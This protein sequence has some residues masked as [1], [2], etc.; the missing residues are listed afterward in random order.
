MGASYKIRAELSWDNDADLDL[1]AEHDGE[2]AWFGHLPTAT[3]TLNQD[4]HPEC[5][6][7]PPVP[8]IITSNAD[9]IADGTFRFWF[10]RYSTCS[11]EPSTITKLIE[12]ENTGDVKIYVNNERIEPTGKK[13]FNV[14]YRVPN[15]GA[16]DGF[17]KGTLIKVSLK[18]AP[19]PRD[20]V[21]APDADG[22]AKP[23]DKNN[24]NPDPLGGRPRWR[25]GPGGGIF[26]WPFWGW[27]GNGGWDMPIFWCGCGTGGPSGWGG[28][29]GGGGGETGGGGPGG[30]GNGN[31]DNGGGGE[32]VEA[33]PKGPRKI[34]LRYPY[35]MKEIWDAIK[36]IR[37]L[38]GGKCDKQ[39]AP[40]NKPTNDA[41]GTGA[42]GFGGGTGDSFGG[43]GTSYGGSGGF[44]FCTVGYSSFPIRYSNGEIQYSVNDIEIGGNG[45]G[46][47]HTR[48][49]SNQLTETSDVGNGNNWLVRQWTYLV[50][51]DDLVYFISDTQNMVVFEYDSMGDVYNALY[52]SKYKLFHDGD[53]FYIHTPTGEMW[54]FW[55]FTQVDN[56]QGG[57]KRML[58]AAKHEIKVLSYVGGQIEEIVRE[59]VVS[60]DDY[61]ESYFYEYISSG[62]LAGRIST[63]TFRYVNITAPAVTDVRQCGYSYYDG[64]T[65]NGS[66]GDLQLVINRIPDGSG[67]W[68]DNSKEYYRYYKNGDTDGDTGLLKF[69]LSPASFAKMSLTQDPLTATD[70][71]LAEYA[72]H[73]FRYDSN[74]RVIEEQIQGG[75]QSYTFA[76][77]LNTPGTTP[78]HWV[79]KTTETRPDGSVNIVFTNHLG[80]VLLSDYRADNSG[81]ADRWINYYVYDSTEKLISWVKPGTVLSYD[82]YSG[83]GDDELAVTTEEDEGLVHVRVYYPD[84]AEPETCGAA[85][86]ML[87]YLAIKKGTGGDEIRLR[88]YGYTER[89]IADLVAYPICRISDFP[90]ETDQV[91]NRLDTL[92]EYQWL[93]D[94]V[95]VSTFQVKQRITTLPVVT[96][97]QNGDDVAYERT[98]IF[99]SYGRPIWERGPLGMI[100]HLQYSEITGTANKYIQDVDGTIVTLPTGWTTPAGAGLNL[101]TDVASDN[102]GRVTQF[103]EPPHNIDGTMVRRATWIVDR[104]D[105]YENWLGSGYSTGSSPNY[106]STF[107]LL[108][109]VVIN[110]YDTIDSNSERIVANRTSGSGKLAPTNTFDQSDWKRRSAAHYNS[111]GQLVYTRE[112]HLIPSSGNGSIG[113]NYD[114]AEYGYDTAGRRNKWVTAAGTISTVAYNSRGLMNEIW[115]G[116]DDTPTGTNNMVQLE[117]REYDT[118][119]QGLDSLLTSITRHVDA[120]NTR[121][122]E[123]AYDWRDRPILEISELGFIVKKELDNLGRVTRIESYLDE[124]DPAQLRARVD[125]FYDNRGNVY[126]V[127]QYAVNQSDGSIIGKITDL[128]WYDGSDR[129]L[130]YQPG[131][132]EPFQKY[133][134][135]SIGR[136]ATSY[137]GLIGSGTDDPATVTGDYIFEQ[138]TAIYD[139]ASNL[140][141]MTGISRY[142]GNTS[143][144]G[145]LIAPPTSGS[146]ARPSYVAVWYDPLGRPTTGADYGTNNNAS[147]TRPTSAPAASDTV[148]VTT[149]EYDSLSQLI[150]IT[151]AQGRVTKLFYD[152]LGRPVEQIANYVASGTAPDENVT[153]RAEYDAGRLSKV[154]AVNATTGD[155]ET[156]MIYGTTLTESDLA[157][158]DLQSATLFPGGVAQVLL[159][160]NRLS[161]VK[162]FND[163]NGTIHQFTFDELGRQ[164]GDEITTFAS[165]VDATVRKISSAF[166]ANGD[167]DSITSYGVS[168]TIL[169]QVKYEY[170]SIGLLTKEY[171]EHAGVKNGSTPYTGYEYDTT[172][173]STEYTHGLRPTAMVYPNGERVRYDYGTSSGF[174]DRLSRIAQLKDTS[175]SL[176]TQYTDLGLGSLVAEDFTEPQVKLNYGSTT[177][178]SYPGFD[179]LNRIQ[180][181]LWRS[182]AGGGV[183]REKL[184]YGFDRDGNPKYRLNQIDTSKS[185]LYALDD[186]NRLTTFKRGTLSSSNTVITSPTRQED[187]SLDK[188]DNWTN[189]DVSVAGSIY[190]AQTRTQNTQNEVTAISQGGGQP[191]WVE[192]E[193]DTNGN[194]TVGP[195]VADPTERWKLSYDGWDRLVGVA[196]GAEGSE[197]PLTSYRYDG[198]HGRISQAGTRVVDWVSITP[199]EW[200]NF[201]LADWNAFV[202]DS[203]R[204]WDHY[205]NDDWQLL[206]T[207]QSLSGAPYK[208]DQYL[209]SLRYLDAPVFRQSTDYPGG[210]A[211][212]G[213]RLYY[214]TDPKMNVTCLVDDT[215]TAVERYLYDPYGMPSYFDGSYGTRSSSAYGNDVLYSGYRCDPVTG[216]YNVRFRDL[217]PQLGRWLTTDP[218]GYTDG[219]NLYGYGAN[220][221]ASLVDPFGLAVRAPGTFEG[222]IPVWGSGLQCAHEFSCGRWGWGLFYCG[223]ALAEAGGFGLILKYSGKAVVLTYRGSRSFT[224]G[225]TF[226]ASR[227]GARSHNLSRFL[228]L[229]KRLGITV[230]K[231]SIKSVAGDTENVIELT[232]RFLKSEPFEELIHILQQRGFYKNEVNAI[233]KDLYWKGLGINKTYREVVAAA[234]EIHAKTLLLNNG[235]RHGLGWFNR[236]ILNWQV[237]RLWR[238]LPH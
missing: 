62:T 8:E 13:Q 49:F 236:L 116:T 154:I 155:Q 84:N 163:R 65:V 130:K 34:D 80:R 37:S 30:S 120:T 26:F 104:P 77:E 181:Q 92:F 228:K 54:E 29:G 109:G 18:P 66:L 206:E 55:D 167:L 71:D 46:W 158:N 216:L 53:V 153:N 139:N 70:N 172:Q 115:V 149:A 68:I 3:L 174:S 140:T 5:D 209:W 31:G 150:M 168:N 110:R 24:Q 214:L 129:L 23:I 223:L 96:S 98:E 203:E 200:D 213:D 32:P 36:N 211:T 17:A 15:N 2:V 75:T 162:S 160:Y 185:D 100:D 207:R 128:A 179:R 42:G 35:S 105:I 44:C 126:K 226:W 199:T 127:V 235:S 136:V 123:Y 67:G 212:A 145:A 218:L 57:F 60:G 43:D 222:L 88:E 143:S 58:D 45:N 165:G 94:D 142:E 27:G 41:A 141:Q 159:G 10:N 19:L 97:A 134:Y 204:T 86:G 152:D 51:D 76:Y 91:A 79:C 180:Q 89:L 146:N 112:Y 102:L 188:T 16:Q 118:D 47:G 195:A 193:Y 131:G 48:S 237:N 234:R 7:D 117:S 93:G 208:D 4:S 189:Y 40:T 50:E 101:V 224:Y 227:F 82:A 219:S 103:L 74:R 111:I 187:F 78:N 119:E 106:D 6:P 164:T 175:S 81:G 215:G 171:Q 229:A 220:N 95:S 190:L 73:F 210:V 173:S 196:A 121:S 231:N 38:F 169:N 148:I 156:E 161:E 225:I 135:D 182:Y 39:G 197:T 151:D 170:D 157:T 177:A 21:P 191:A 178:G 147:F 192:P 183:D 14:I 233:V 176:L 184:D 198:L 125:I 63:V 52:G 20:K 221:P 201:D 83:P 72:D 166:T 230:R 124:V 194:M 28:S 114:Q 137:I 90:T 56:P 144:T 113:T 87:H 107:T 9:F 1:Y 202:Y 11:A 217:H 61:Q 133:A 205:Y 108:T 33:G 232:K 85:P 186:L 138:A 59:Y 22:V 12:V 132:S 64:T 69:I 122:T 238:G 99:D 25:P